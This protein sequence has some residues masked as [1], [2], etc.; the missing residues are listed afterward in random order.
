[1]TRQEMLYLLLLQARANGFQFRKWYRKSLDEEWLSFEVALSH[2]ATGKRYYALLFSHDFA[3]CFWK[4]GAQ[5]SFI[6]PT[7]SYT[8]KNKQGEVITVTRKAF[9]RRTLKDDS[10]RYHLREMVAA[11]EPLRYIRR[12]IV[13]QEDLELYRSTHPS[14]VDLLFMDEVDHPVH[15]A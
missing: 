7:A 14:A 1:M 3:Q 9:T 13:R 2:I 11:E 6:V 5:I 8:R 4:P 10:W 12:F 15:P